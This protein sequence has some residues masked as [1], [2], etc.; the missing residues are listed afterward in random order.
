MDTPLPFT[1]N[2]QSLKI[3]LNNLNQLGSHRASN[4]LYEMLQ[5]VYQE[6]FDTQAKLELLNEL[7]TPV[8][9]YS[10]SLEQIVM[11]QE[12]FKNE[13][14]VRKTTTLSSELLRLLSLNYCKISVT[15][16]LTP[17]QH[18]MTIYTALHL[19]GLSM[20]KRAT[21]NQ[22]PSETLW[23]KT[24]E[25]YLRAQKYQLLERP[26][27]LTTLFTSRQSSIMEVL[28]R[29]LLFTLCDPYRFTSATIKTLFQFAE[30]YYALLNSA[31]Q[32]AQADFVWVYR[33]QGT[34]LPHVKSTP[35]V[36]QTL[37]LSC[38]AITDMLAVQ[39]P[40]NLSKA[41]LFHL[42]QHLCG[43]VDIIDSAIPSEATA[44]K[45]IV[46]YQ[47]IHAYLNHHA[48]IQN[49]HRISTSSGKPRQGSSF[50]QLMPLNAPTQT[51][52]LSA[53]TVNS[54]DPYTMPPI[55]VH[56]TRYKNYYVTT[57]A[58][59]TLQIGLPVL[60]VDKV[61]NLK[62]GV[63]RQ[64]ATHPI[65]LSQQILIEHIEGVLESINLTLDAQNTLAILITKATDEKEVMLPELRV[66]SGTPLE[67]NSRSTQGHFLLAE[68]LQF[69]AHYRHYKIIP[70]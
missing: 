28:H 18:A 11:A 43:Y 13:A 9:S 62:L 15:P 21:L 17:E 45:L 1:G 27:T 44:C 47:H 14:L 35:P 22:F 57:T 40:L 7:A 42:R 25:L 12:C 3:W 26:I 6:T 53:I 51:P 59:R 41:D 36:S 38:R 8:I 50:L 31:T 2:K 32:A 52:K 19:I 49:I 48:T 64:I 39:N 23:K 30:S 65:A 24:T 34:P 67:I 16:N 68:L 69:T 4:K 55:S 58:N 61:D 60:L 66:Q 56:P 29:N 70:H 37:Y 63:I 5:V 54:N 33:Q 46:D 10:D 20:R